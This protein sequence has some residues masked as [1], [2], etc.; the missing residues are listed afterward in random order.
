MDGLTTVPTTCFF[1]PS[2][3]GGAQAEIF[4][5][6]KFFFSFNV[7]TVSD[8]NLKILDIVARWPGSVHDTTIF[9][10]SRLCTRF[11]NNEINNAVLVSDA[12][13]PVKNNLLTPLSQTHTRGE[14]LYNEAL[15]RTRNPVE[16]SYGVWKRRFPILSNGINLNIAKV[17]R[18]IV[19]TAVLHN[20]AIENN[21]EDPPPLNQREE[22][23]FNQAIDVP[24]DLIEKI[25]AAI[26]LVMK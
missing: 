13:Y 6:R 10:N 1:F 11:K 16:R 14:N 21:E 24:V 22:A 7:Q 25:M 4:R 9:R 2:C 5:N 17:Q 15:I 12:G 18:I 23:L 3:S 26:L 20:I 8:A 19:A